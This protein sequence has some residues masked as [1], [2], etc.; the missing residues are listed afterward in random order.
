MV[1]IAGVAGVMVVTLGEEEQDRELEASWNQQ[2][3]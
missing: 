3:V 1:Q 2:R